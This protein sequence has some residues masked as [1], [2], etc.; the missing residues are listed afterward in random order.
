MQNKQNPYA[1]ISSCKDFSANANVGDALAWMEEEIHPPSQSVVGGSS[2]P[3]GLV[4]SSASGVD[5][6]AGFRT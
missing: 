4:C 5:V 2:F 1:E 6:G 3:A